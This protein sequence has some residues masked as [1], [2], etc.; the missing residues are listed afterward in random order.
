MSGEE[1]IIRTG[2]DQELVHKDEE[3][4]SFKRG[5]LDE[6]SFELDI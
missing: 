1:L 2:K 5:T 4:E 3:A 6:V